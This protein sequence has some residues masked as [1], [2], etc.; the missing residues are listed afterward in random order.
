MDNVAPKREAFVVILAAPPI[1]ETR[2]KYRWR[3]EDF[4][5]MAGLEFEA[6]RLKIVVK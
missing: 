1:I 4:G 5:G 2:A 6:L 3:R